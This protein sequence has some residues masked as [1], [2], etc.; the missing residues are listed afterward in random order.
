MSVVVRG[1][2]LLTANGPLKKIKD[3]QPAL[4]VLGG[5]CEDYWFG[6]TAPMFSYCTR[7]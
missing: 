3:H 6:G 7:I 4:V 2:R 1:I 5:I